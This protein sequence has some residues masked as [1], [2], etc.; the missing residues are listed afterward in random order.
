[1]RKSLA[2]TLFTTAILASGSAVSGSLNFVKNASGEHEYAQLYNLPERFGTGEFTL[3]LWVKPDASYPMGETPWPQN[4]YPE[5]EGAIN[6]RAVNDDQ[7]TNWSDADEKPYS[8]KGWWWHGNWLL[9]GFSRNYGGRDGSFALQFYGGGRLRW[10]FDDGTGPSEEKG[11]VYSVGAYPA[12]NT[13]SL[14]DGRWH[15][16]QAVR[17][18]SGEKKAVLELWIDGGLIAKTELPSRVDMQ[19]KYWKDWKVGNP[20]GLEGWF[21]GGEEQAVTGVHV[22][23]LWN[24]FEDYK[25]LVD[26]IKFWERAKTPRELRQYQEVIISEAKAGLVGYF[27]FEKLNEP[28]RHLVRDKLNEQG[29]MSLH[30][31]QSIYFSDE[32]PPLTK[33]K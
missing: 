20:P 2:V 12:S 11:Y 16:I 7:L 24:Q 1:M 18:W 17:R 28:A 13:P 6:E 31:W 22:D 4:P 27:D 23:Y 15:N 19:A 26:E 21:I 14:L 3:E 9:D 8:W 25:G 10:F 33:P 32:N 5:N 29:V 30:R